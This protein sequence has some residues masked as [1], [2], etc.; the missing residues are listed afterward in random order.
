M[1]YIYTKLKQKKKAHI[2]YEK[3]LKYDKEDITTWLEYSS[4]LEDVDPTKA[5]RSYL[6]ALELIKK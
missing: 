3:A 4:F 6:Q 2:A 5:L 1:G